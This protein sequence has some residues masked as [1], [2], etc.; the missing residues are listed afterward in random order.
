MLDRMAAAEVVY[1]AVCPGHSKAIVELHYGR[2]T[3]EGTYF[4]S[5]CLDKVPMLRDAATGDWV[6]SFSGHKG[7]V[8]SA[9]LNSDAS[10]AATGSA[11]F[12]VKLWDAVDGVEKATLEH[13][14]IVKSV[15]FTA[16]DKRLATG[17]QDRKLRIYDLASTAA[18]VAEMMHAKG[19]RKV[20]WTPDARCI[21]TGAD[22]GV[23]RIW[24][25]ASGS[26]VREYVASASGAAVM[27]VELSWDASTLTVAA[28]QSVHLL[29]AADLSVRHKYDFRYVVES[30]SL[31]PGSGSHFIAGGT[32]VH[33]HVHATATGEE[34]VTERGHHGTVHA[35]RFAPDGSTFASGADDATV[36][37]WKFRTTS[38]RAGTVGAPAAAP[39]A[40]AGGA[41]SA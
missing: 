37:L 25:V 3:A 4:I 29:S 38:P 36:R 14:H 12:S 20:L 9:K 33:V 1:P 23:V 5:A 28:G 6:G 2:P 15:D 11:D 26:C 30:A 31:M 24:D 8:W 41:G 7:A 35:V 19:V 10:L 22:D 34:V 13:S 18:P 32:D 27:D 16:D 17:T 21:V 39:A 40:V